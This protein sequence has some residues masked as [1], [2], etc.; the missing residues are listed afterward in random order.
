MTPLWLTHV[1]AGAKLS[2]R[3][4]VGVA[5]LHRTLQVLIINRVSYTLSPYPVEGQ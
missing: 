2:P 1:G 5:L 4:E 3:Y